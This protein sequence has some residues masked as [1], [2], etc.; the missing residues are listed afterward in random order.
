MV[1]GKHYDG[2]SSNIRSGMFNEI[3]VGAFP[4]FLSMLPSGMVCVFFFLFIYF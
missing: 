4:A 1:F 2:Y 3:A